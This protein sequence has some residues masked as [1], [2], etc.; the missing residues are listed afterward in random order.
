MRV[1]ELRRPI[2]SQPIPINRSF[3]AA[4]VFKPA[5]G[6]MGILQRRLQGVRKLS[7]PHSY[8]RHR[9]ILLTAL[10]RESPDQCCQLP[11][12]L[13]ETQHYV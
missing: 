13:H 7:E 9:S 5:N 8:V 3:A 10:F 11:N 12:S 2:L 6:P 4:S 1:L